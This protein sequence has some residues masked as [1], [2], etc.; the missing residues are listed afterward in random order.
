MN[1]RP[2][3]QH[4]LNG[5]AA[6]NN[7]T[8]INGISF[9]SP[10]LMAPMSQITDAPF[11][12]F[13]ETMGAGG[14]VGELISAHGIL[15]DNKKTK[16]MLKV[17]P[18]EKHVGL[19]LFGED[20]ELM[21]QAAEIMQEFSPQ[22]IDINMGCP[23]KKVVTKGAGSALLKDVSK[24]PHFFSSIRKRV[25]LPLSIKIRLGWDQQ[26][27]N[28]SE[29]VHIAAEEGIQMIA[30]HGR[31]RCQ[32]YAG[33]ADW[34]HIEEVATKSPLPIIGN[35]DLTSAEQIQQ[36]WANTHCAALMMGRGPLKNPFLFLQASVPEFNRFNFSGVDVFCAWKLLLINLL[37]DESINPQTVFI[38]MRNHGLWFS[39][40]LPH[41]KEFRTQV[42][43]VKDLSS[44]E[45]LIE[46]FFSQFS[47]FNNTSE[48]SFMTAGHG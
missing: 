35:G 16:Q 37:E 39:H 11:R 24:L 31:T 14:T 36:R 34:E 17:H 32:Q 43:T 22:F 1:F 2:E 27:K 12:R 41:A 40:G 28:A 42:F 48:E 30:I 47:Q 7:P 25:S 45:L 3:I 33:K 21:G 18:K 6:K 20:P 44:L 5:L 46:D 8:I 29:V 38:R 15:Y 19:Q 10:F 9:S 23:V 26:S 13:M 4:A